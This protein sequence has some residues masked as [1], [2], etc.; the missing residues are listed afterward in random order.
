[1]EEIKPLYL[2][3]SE[4][5][6]SYSWKILWFNVK[7][8]K[9]IAEQINIS[10]SQGKMS[11]PWHVT[12]QDKRKQKSWNKYIAIVIAFSALWK[13]SAGVRHLKLEKLDF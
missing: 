2:E 13:Y 4:T 5:L 1:M 10:I 7:H 8:K 11:S 6:L 12:L 3:T 9:D